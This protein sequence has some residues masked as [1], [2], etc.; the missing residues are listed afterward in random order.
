MCPSVLSHARESLIPRCA[1]LGLGLIGARREEDTKGAILDRP[2]NPEG[3]GS[4]FKLVK[5]RSQDAFLFESGCLV[6]FYLHHHFTYANCKWENCQAAKAE[7]GKRTF[8][9]ILCCFYKAI[10]DLARSLMKK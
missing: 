8:S 6:A 10:S 3:Y 7:E 9:L 1:A 4:A 2:V 5:L